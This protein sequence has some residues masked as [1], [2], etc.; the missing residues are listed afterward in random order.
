MSD[1]GDVHGANCVYSRHWS[2]PWY[3]INVYSRHWSLPWY[4]INVST[5][6][7]DG[8]HGAR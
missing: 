3:K 2:L 8:C 4:N 5:A 7:T 1:I 6:D